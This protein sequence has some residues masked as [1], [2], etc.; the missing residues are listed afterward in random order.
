MDWRNAAIRPDGY[1]GSQAA[2]IATGT[3]TG[4]TVQHPAH[5]LLDLNVEV[6]TD[7][8]T[9]GIIFSRSTDPIPTAKSSHH[10][11]DIEV[12]CPT[13]HDLVVERA[14]QDEIR[15]HVRDIQPAAAV[16]VLRCECATQRGG[17]YH[18]I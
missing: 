14:L 12:N 15:S 3:V 17:E 16:V 11:A 8:P 2:D 18:T 5:A 9:K 4:K 7:A 10:C 1:V 13:A 6:G